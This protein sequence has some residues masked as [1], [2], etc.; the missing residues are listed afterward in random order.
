MNIALFFLN[1]AKGLCTKKLRIILINY[2]SLLRIYYFGTKNLNISTL[3]SILVSIK[4]ILIALNVCGQ[5]KQRGRELERKHI[6]PG[7]YWKRSQSA[8]QG[9]KPIQSRTWKARRS[10]R[11]LCQNSWRAWNN[12]NQHQKYRKNVKNEMKG[13]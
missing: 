2:G 10:K 7:F 12:H 13:K 11:R 9:W 4:R 5:L 3:K 6:I 1:H 8:L